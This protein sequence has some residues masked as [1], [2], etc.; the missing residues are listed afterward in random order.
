MFYQREFCHA[1][2]SDRL[3][4]FLRPAKATKRARWVCHSMRVIVNGESCSTCDGSGKG[5]AIAGLGAL[6][7]RVASNS[8]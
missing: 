6:P 1:S 3:G 7:L 2:S 4:R 8:Q 5:A